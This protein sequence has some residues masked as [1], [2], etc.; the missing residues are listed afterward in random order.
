MYRWA[1]SW[2]RKCVFT[3]VEEFYWKNALVGS[4]TEGVDVL[5]YILKVEHAPG[6]YLKKFITRET[7]DGVSKNLPDF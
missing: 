6:M 1:K 2:L 5:F 3:F 4:L 7:F